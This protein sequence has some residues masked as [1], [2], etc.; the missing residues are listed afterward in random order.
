MSG[1][2]CRISCCFSS[3]RLKMM[4]LW[5]RF[6][7][8]RISINF[9]PKDPV[10][11]VTRTVA[12]DQSS[13]SNLSSSLFIPTTNSL[14]AKNPFPNFWNRVGSALETTVEKG[15]LMAPPDRY[16]MRT[17]SPLC[18]ITC[19]AKRTDSR[20][21]RSALSPVDS[22]NSEP[23]LRGVNSLGDLAVKYAL[24]EVSVMSDQWSVADV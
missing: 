15:R 6:S 5:G 11:P 4:S 23:G 24:T 9:L 8:R 1:N 17:N 2:T 19:S 3:S 12:L 14:V 18:A 21:R 16:P 13:G 7:L 10:P 20:N 22:L